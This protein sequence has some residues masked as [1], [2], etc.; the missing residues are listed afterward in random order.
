MSP[1]SLIFTS[2]TS[3]KR[4]HKHKGQSYAYANV[5]FYLKKFLM[6]PLVLMLML[7]SLVKTRL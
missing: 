1:L 4:K 7:K 2:D 6:P 3:H 5:R